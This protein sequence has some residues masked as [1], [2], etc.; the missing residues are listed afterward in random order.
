M[1]E[2]AKQY[3]KQYKILSVLMLV[4][5]LGAVLVSGD[6]TGADLTQGDSS[7][8]VNQTVT[9]LNAQA[10][11]VTALN[12]D[13]V[14]ITE[15]WQGFYGNV[16]GRITLDNADNE[17][18]YDWTAGT[19]QGEILASRTVVSSWTNIDCSSV[20]FRENEDTAL[21][22]TSTWTDSIN[23]TF[24]STST[25]TF[26]IGNSGDLSSC[27]GVQAYNNAGAGTFWNT[28]INVSTT[29]VYVSIINNDQN[30]FNGDGTADF[31]LLVPTNYSE[32]GVA[33]YY[34]YVELS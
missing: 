6:P 21:G 15:V 2:R 34:F 28:L 23:S 25:P 8:R 12:I 24:N 4:I 22:I 27:N 9:S 20:T 32:G 29:P 18:F 13:Q 7:R 11:N 10:G 14:K 19:T 3:T 1:K 16:S 30:A 31:E 33:T 17:T 26:Q 5:I